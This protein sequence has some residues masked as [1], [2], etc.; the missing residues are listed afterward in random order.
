MSETPE[1][2]SVLEAVLY[3]DA[4]QRA[5]MHSFCEELLGL[6]RVAAWETGTAYRIGSGVLLIFDR[7]RLADERSPVS[8]H[9]TSGPGHACFRAEGGV[10]DTIRARL[11]EA[12]VEIRHDHEWP[13]GGRSFYFA[14]PAGNLLEVADRDIWPR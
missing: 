12:G 10:Y 13:G 4:D 8:A 7:D 9:G 3:Y 6:R 1:L 2:D 11:E 14:D 5:A